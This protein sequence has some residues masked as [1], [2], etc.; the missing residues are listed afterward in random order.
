[1]AGVVTV[2]TGV[3]HH[4][5][6]QPPSE[7]GNENMHDGRTRKVEAVGPEAKQPFLDRYRASLT[8]TRGPAAGTEFDL[9]DV[10]TIIGR[11][12]DARIQIDDPSVS[13]EHA[14]IE[15]D[16]QGFGIRDLASTNHVL[17]NGAEVLS[18]ALKHGDRIQLG[19]C[20]LQLVVEE[21]APRAK[22]WDV[23]EDS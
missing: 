20:E 18:S 23:S 1:V 14:S 3:L 10:R 12:A 16:A 6:L 17:V 22:A 11:S 15:L 5:G 13:S 7:Q 21:R 19:N 9:D 2:H 8:I 4:G